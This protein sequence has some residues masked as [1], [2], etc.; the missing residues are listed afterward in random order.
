[1]SKSKDYQHLLNSKRWKQ[2]R[3]WKLQQNPLCELCEAEGKIVSAVDVHHMTPVETART[4]QEMEQLCFNP[5]NLQAL[6]I[7]C[8][9]D[10]H[11]NAKSHTKE[12]HK[13][14]ERD[15]LERW[16]AELERR[17]ADI[18]AKKPTDQNPGGVI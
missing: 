13:Q 11:R 15:R 14:R 10:I 5:S 17:V 7:S 18:Q 1:M 3:Q 9:A 16:K 6:C 2:L 12:A 8:H 4:P